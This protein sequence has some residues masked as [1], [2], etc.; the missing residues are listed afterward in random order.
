M[1]ENKRFFDA[2]KRTQ[3]SMHRYLN[4]TQ[5]TLCI[6]MSKDIIEVIIDDMFF[7]P[8]LDEDEDDEEFEPITKTNAMKLFKQQP[9]GSYVANV[10]TLTWPSVEVKPNT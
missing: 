8:E 9:D 2:K 10:A 7:K 1:E 6:P 3:D 4:A 5:T